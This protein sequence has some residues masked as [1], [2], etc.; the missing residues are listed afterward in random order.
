MLIWPEQRRQL[1]FA[2]KLQKL[3][4][5]TTR[6]HSVSVHSISCGH[7]HNAVLDSDGLLYT[8][9]KNN[10]GQLGHGTLKSI[11]TPQLVTHPLRAVPIASVACGWLHTLCVTSAGQVYAWGCNGDGQLGTGDK[12]DR[13]WPIHVPTEFEPRQ[14]AAG[15]LHSACVSADRCLHT[16]GANPDGRLFVEPVQIKHGK[17]KSQ[18]V[19]VKTELAGVQQVA[20]G[21]SHTLVLD[22]LGHVFAAGSTE[23]GQLGTGQNC[24][25][26]MT[27]AR[28]TDDAVQVACGDHFSCVLKTDGSVH[29]FG[30]GSMG[31]LGLGDEA[32]QLAPV[33]VP[34]QDKVL[35]LSCGGR[36]C[37]ALGESGEV[38]AWGY[39]FCNQLGTGKQEDRLLPVQL[40]LKGLRTATGVACGYLHSS[41]LI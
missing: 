14:V 25:A 2:K 3:H 24:S 30:K 29:S 20:L 1:Q 41:L 12:W 6:V 17:F 31:R 15:R 7:F 34:L 4:V 37:L 21:F 19:P 36:H 33:R 23:H 40:P 8:F 26:S 9:G 11:A 16:W 22:E 5:P 27:C 32:D 10:S 18:R 38:Y 13:S 28:C 35:Q 39:G